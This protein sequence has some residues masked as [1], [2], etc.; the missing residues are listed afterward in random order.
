[1]K[2]KA[3]AT[4]KAK[5]VDYLKRTMTETVKMVSAHFPCVL[6]TGARQV[7]KSTL[8][9]RIMPKGMRY[10]SLDSVATARMA[11]QDPEGFLRAYGT[12]LCIDE[13]QY[14]PALMRSIKAVV[15]ANRRNG[16]YWLTGSQRFHLMQG[17]SESLAG[18]IAVL[19]LYSLSQRESCG[20]GGK[21]GWLDPAN[22]ALAAS[23]MRAC[24]TD[25]LLE[26]IVRGG[27]P[28][29]VNDPGMPSDVFFESYVNSYLERDVSALT[30]VGD[31]GA[32]LQ[33]M[34]I[35][36][37]RTGEQLSYAKVA[38]AAELSPSTAKRWIS[39]LE[40]SGIITML[41]PYCTNSTKR[42]VKTPKMH[43]MDSGL[44]A[45]LAGITSAAHLK[46]SP[47]LGHIVESW[48]F[49]QLLRG[50][51]N[52]GRT[53]RIS[54]FRDKAGH[55]VDMLL[56]ENGR[57]YPIEVKLSGTPSLDDLAA[58]RHIPTGRLKL[59]GGIIVCNIPKPLPLGFDNIALPISAI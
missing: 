31:K 48:V 6:L 21:A 15:D 34:R 53:C 44:C 32:F 40:T 57:L 29:M 19:E 16:M 9:R 43:F 24:G 25:E 30:Q 2:A 10:V 49:G 42:L 8:L 45:W 28:E 50:Y 27:Y 41:H 4:A 38:Q 14:A 3:K 36:A 18:R 11:E 26:R 1:M 39:I 22:P 17:L 23:G 56:E 13:I 37:L 46:N 35:L 52:N 5:K 55:E 7:G 20:K 54:Y 51:A 12:P 59:G 47:L 33:L 58:V